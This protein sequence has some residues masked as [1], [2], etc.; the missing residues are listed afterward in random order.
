MLGWP[1]LGQ[2]EKKKSSRSDPDLL[3]PTIIQHYANPFVLN[4]PMG[5]F[6]VMDLEDHIT[7]TTKKK[8]IA[9]WAC[10]RS[11]FLWPILWSLVLL[12]I[13][14]R[15]DGSKDVCNSYKCKEWSFFRRLSATSPT[16]VIA[17][18]LES[19]FCTWAPWSLA[20]FADSEVLPVL[21]PTTFKLIHFMRNH[22]HAINL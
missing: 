19:S 9:L 15:I 16:A 2:F 17:C 22:R 20:A 5:S 21:L 1:Y 13:L 10:G 14:S 6:L 18:T 7:T 12:Q 11:L 4:D 8:Q 3:S